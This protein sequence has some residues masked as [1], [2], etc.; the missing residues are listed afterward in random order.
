MDPAVRLVALSGRELLTLHAELTWSRRE[1]LMAAGLFAV[2]E[3]RILTQFGGITDGVT[4]A[5]AGVLPGD[6]LHIVALNRPPSVLVAG[7]LPLPVVEVWGAD[8]ARRD[9]VMQDFPD[10][11]SAAEFT[12]DGESV[13]VACDDGT[14]TRWE[15]GTGISRLLYACQSPISALAC[16]PTGMCV[17]FL[18]GEHEVRAVNAQTGVL[19]FREVDATASLTFLR[20]SADGAHILTAGC[21][22]ALRVWPHRRRHVFADLLGHTRQVLA[23]AVAPCGALVGT[24]SADGTLRLWSLSEERARRAF[25]SGARA[26]MNAVSFARGG[27]FIVGGSSEGD[28]LWWSVSTGSLLGQ[29]HHGPGAITS[30]SATLS[31][32]ELVVSTAAGT[33]AVVDGSTMTTRAVRLPQAGALLDFVSSVCWRP[34]VPSLAAFSG[35]ADEGD[36]M[37]WTEVM[38]AMSVES[39]DADFA[40]DEDLDIDA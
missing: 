1:V 25:A 7:C 5:G 17:A 24:A 18:I 14:L 28:V 6:T 22:A 27:G 10:L 26:Q 39:A 21:A 40:P 31:A 29:V 38:T 34:C 2:S 33:V 9:I 4:L 19:Y 11:V 3:Y 20:W 8:L 37:S 23:A 36:A 35:G 30:V 16:C 13:L 12:P 32:T 15:W